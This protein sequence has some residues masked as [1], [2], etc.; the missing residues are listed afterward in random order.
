MKI[1][2][3]IAAHLTKLLQKNA[4]KWNEEATSVFEQPKLAMTTI[5]VLALPDW[6]L[7]FTIET[8]ASGV[9]LGVVLSQGDILS[10][11][12]IR[13]YQEPNLSLYMKGN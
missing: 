1:Y 11:S 2:G 7:S 4:F 6:S 8:D 12:S 5:S 13:N 10:P 9:G 3:E